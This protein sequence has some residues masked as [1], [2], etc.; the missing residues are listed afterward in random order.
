VGAEVASEVALS[1]RV[2]ASGG[3]VVYA[4]GLLMAAGRRF[5]GRPQLWRGLSRMLYHRGPGGLGVALSLFLYGFVLLGPY[6]GLVQAIR[7]Y[8]AL[9][10]PSLIGIGA[11]H[12]IR[13]ATALRLRQS[14]NGIVLHPVG[15]LW[16]I[17]ILLNSLRRS[18]AG[19]LLWAGRRYEV[20]AA[21]EP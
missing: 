7:G 3:R 10:M 17:A 9:L 2:K 20:G 1:S 16:M 6:V 5:Q 21:K 15:L 14:S 11:N 4:D 8:Q 13:V 12:A 19:V 18:R